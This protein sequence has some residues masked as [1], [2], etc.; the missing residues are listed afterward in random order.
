MPSRARNNPQPPSGGLIVMATKRSMKCFNITEVE[1]DTLGLTHWIS[2]IC[3]SVGTALLTFCIDTTKDLLIAG[4][5]VTPNAIGLRFSI[6]NFG[7]PGA[8]IFFG[9]G[10]LAM[11]YWGSNIRRIKRESEQLDPSNR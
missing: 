5:P 1:I 7:F 10:I 3:F 11:I 2:A 9:I 4:S 6:Y 8:L